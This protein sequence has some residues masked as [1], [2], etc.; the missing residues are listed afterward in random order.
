MEEKR[1]RTVA[2]SQVTKQCTVCGLECVG[3]VV[4]R[5]GRTSKEPRFRSQHPGGSSQRSLT[6]AF[7]IWCPLLVANGTRPTCSAQ[8]YT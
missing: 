5:A 4:K 8:T 1:T 6:P 2:K 3:S 7:R